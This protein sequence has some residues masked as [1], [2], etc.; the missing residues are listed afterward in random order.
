MGAY[1][2]CTPLGLDIRNPQDEEETRWCC[3]GGVTVENIAE[4]ED[5]ME[6]NGQ[7]NV[8]REEA[9]DLLSSGLLNNDVTP[10]L[11]SEAGLEFKAQAAAEG[12]KLPKKGKGGSKDDKQGSNGASGPEVVVPLDV[13]D[14]AR[15]L[16]VKARPP[17]ARRP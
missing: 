13:A 14:E 11:A 17:P 16:I 4:N 7:Q 10:V 12:A 1:A 3:D 15:A 2:A 6:V 8:D 9:L 5:S